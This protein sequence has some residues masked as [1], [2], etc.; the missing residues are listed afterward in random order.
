M[1]EPLRFAMM[2]PVRHVSQVYQSP[3]HTASV[4]SLCWA[5]YE[6][7]LALAA[8]SSDG[9][10]SVLT[11][12]PDGSWHVDKASVSILPYVASGKLLEVWPAREAHPR[13]PLSGR[14][15]RA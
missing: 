7:G 9:S 3:L 4:N 2:E 15:R 6:L 12:Q 11:Y 13:C 1:L 5:P 14:W 8:A 10:I